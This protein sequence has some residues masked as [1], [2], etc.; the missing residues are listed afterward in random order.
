M[1]KNNQEYKDTRSKIA[2]MISEVKSLKKLL[3]EKGLAAQ[4]IKKALDPQV[5]FLLG[6]VDEVKAYR[7]SLNKKD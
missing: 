6:F 2:E 4:D 5:T 3:K 7:K 1:I